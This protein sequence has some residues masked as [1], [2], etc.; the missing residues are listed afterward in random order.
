[1]VEP[2]YKDTWMTIYHGDCREV[3]PSLPK[4]DL[5]VSDPP[6]GIAYK[7]QSGRINGPNVQY[8]NRFE[9]ELI[10][11]DEAAF[12][13]STI[14]SLNIPSILWGGNHFAGSLPSHSKWLVWDKR[15]GT[16][17]VNDFGDCELAWTNLEGSGTRIFRHF[18]DG[19]NKASERG[20]SRVHPTQKPV[21][22]M[23]WCIQLLPSAELILDPYMGSGSTLKAAKLLGKQAIGIE[24]EERYCEIAAKRCESI[25]AGL[26][27]APVVPVAHEPQP[28][29]FGE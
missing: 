14:L 29:F 3:L 19:F 8:A 10:V 18:W 9:G 25:Q 26:F 12:D 23:N 20:I 5:V 28:A 13:P 15:Y 11:G 17:A 4:A 1:M 22:L 16:T 2:Y 6:Y 27:D 7:P 21:A 24:I